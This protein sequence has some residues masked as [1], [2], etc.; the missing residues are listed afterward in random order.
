MEKGIAEEN[1][2]TPTDNR[3]HFDQSDLDRVQRRLKQRH[4]QMH[5]FLCIP[6]WLTVFNHLLILQDRCEC[7]LRSVACSFG[8]IVS[9]YP[10]ADCRDDWNR[11][12]PWVRICTRRCWSS[13]RSARVLVGWHGGIFVR[14][15]LNMPWGQRTSTEQ[16][17][18]LHW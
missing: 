6:S 16:I 14:P 9:V 7:L 10:R 11:F 8:L 2:A 3:Y 17:A 4:V 12:I 5:V 1:Y 15:S 13:W 18:M